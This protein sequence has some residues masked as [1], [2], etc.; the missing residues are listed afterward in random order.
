MLSV[1]VLVLC[2]CVTGAAT[3][4]AGLST[5]PDTA[6]ARG[7]TTHHQTGRGH[8][9]HARTVSCAKQSSFHARGR[10]HLRHRHTRCAK[11]HSGSHHA[12]HVRRHRPAVGP[13]H[14]GNSCSGAELHPTQENIETIRTATL[15]LIDQER[16]AHG[17]AALQF[18]AHLQQSAQTHTESM[19][20]G[21]YFEHTGP[22]GDTP[23][24][25][26]TASGYIP[27]SNVGYEI[28]ENIGWGTLDLGTPHA[29]VAAWMAS[30][31]H[32]ANILDASFKDTAIGVSP[33]V[34]SSLGA[35]QP[36]GI[37]TQDFGVIIAG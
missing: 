29:I 32:R 23:L 16:A 37:Y 4:L 26:M 1:L 24:S 27:S 28:G 36:G 31:G 9:R 3:A 5:A 33:H 12:H 8:H 7:A 30:P 34:P 35:G 18:D 2:L 21:N 19:A 20:F 6:A 25:R 13:A 14:A 10:I 11:L 22:G 17:E 15:C